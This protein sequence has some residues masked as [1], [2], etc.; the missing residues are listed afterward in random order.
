MNYDKEKTDDYTKT[1]VIRHILEYLIHMTPRSSPSMLLRILM[2]R[3]MDN[4]RLH[5]NKHKIRAIRNAIARGKSRKLTYN[6]VEK[7]HI[8]PGTIHRMRVIP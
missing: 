5:L 6:K 3:I 2:S 1:A 7:N 8:Q 4:Y